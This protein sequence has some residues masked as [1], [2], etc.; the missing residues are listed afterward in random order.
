MHHTLTHLTTPPQWEDVSGGSPNT[1]VL[2][3]MPPPFPASP[4][5]LFWGGGPL[6]IRAEPPLGLHAQSL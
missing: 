1:T 2:A 6:E 5:Q 3:G 4:Q